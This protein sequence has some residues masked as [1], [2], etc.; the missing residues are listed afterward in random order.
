MKYLVAVSG[1]V[2]SVVLLD[3]LSRTDHQL[4]VAHVDHGI[5]GNESEAD[6]RF[7][8]RL[9]KRYRVPFV[10]A[11]LHLGASAGEDEAR[12]A[13]YAFLREQSARLSAVI[14]TAHHKEDAVETIAINLVRGTGWRGL[15]AMETK[16]ILRPLL[17]LTKQQIYEYAA[18]RRL[19]W[20]ED[21]T[22]R[23]D[24]YLRNR[25]R[26]RLYATT[27]ARVWEQCFV[28]RARQLQLRRD[29]EKETARIVEGKEPSRHFFAQIDMKTG[30]ELL[31]YVLRGRNGV[32]PTRPQL[33]RALLAIRTAKPGS[34]YQLGESTE[35]HFTP[36][37]FSVKR[38]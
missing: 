32:R 15:S 19:E 25:I 5:R 10:S 21:V 26:K 29:I 31:G 14:V 17:T 27:D 7:V 38:V 13:R 35:L 33:E 2:D 30:V 18:N 22:N 6:A 37:A 34:I 28:L 20:V 3:M 24:N 16:G 36:R 23:T 11:A 1:G 8:E 12:R 9:A 4:V